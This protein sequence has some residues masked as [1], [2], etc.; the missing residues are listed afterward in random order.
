MS[1]R[2]TPQFRCCCHV[3]KFIGHP[4]LL[5]TDHVRNSI[6]SR[7]FLVASLPRLD[8]QMTLLATTIIRRASRK[9]S[10]DVTR[11]FDTENEN[12]NGVGVLPTLCVNGAL[13]I[14][15]RPDARHVAHVLA[16][17]GDCRGLNS[18]THNW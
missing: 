18:R 9:L 15:E 4:E 3:C 1:C 14:A 11:R 17:G 5:S 13:A 6:L 12:E 7:L 8:V 2:L 10:H 16:V